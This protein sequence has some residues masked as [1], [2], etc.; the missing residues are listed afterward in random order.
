MSVSNW[1]KLIEIYWWSLGWIKYMGYTLVTVTMAIGVIGVS[2][3]REPCTLVDR[4][5]VLHP[6]QQY[7]MH[8]TPLSWQQAGYQRGIFWMFTYVWFI[9]SICV[10][11]RVCV[12][13]LVSNWSNFIP[14]WKGSQKRQ[15]T[16]TTV[17]CSVAVSCI[18]LVV[19]PPYIQSISPSQKE[20]SN[21]DMSLICTCNKYCLS[22]FWRWSHTMVCDDMGKKG[23]RKEK[24][25][26]DWTRASVLQTYSQSFG[27]RAMVAAGGL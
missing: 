23:V 21:L 9:V 4:V 22:L 5:F 10:C 27:S 17:H 2:S 3:V 26:N 14:K 16:T 20:P 15:S 25:S 19:K 7:I 13:W 24:S 6:E 18:W 12:G 1:E 8:Y 11:A